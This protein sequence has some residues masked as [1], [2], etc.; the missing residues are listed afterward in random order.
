MIMRRIIFI[1]VVLVIVT[2]SYGQE[3]AKR[4]V[5]FIIMVDGK[6]PLSN[7]D[8]HLHFIVKRENQK[9]DTIEADYIPG[10][11][12]LEKPDFFKL[13]S[14]DVKS[15]SLEI[16]YKGLCKEEIK[17]YVYKIDF[18]KSWLQFDFTILR[19]YNLNSKKNKKIFF[20]LEGQ[21]YTYE[22]DSPNGSMIRVKKR[23]DKENCD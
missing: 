7:G 8:A 18:Y 12:I 21:K 3:A 14:D 5:N 2:K 4:N 16:H 9:I 6:I 11:I 22:M 23:N 13:Q 19:I 17:S 20:P 10:D 15:I 1:L